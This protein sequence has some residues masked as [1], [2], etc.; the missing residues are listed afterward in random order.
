M[1]KVRVGLAI[2]LFSLLVSI[3]LEPV[4][5]GGAGQTEVR[6]SASLPWNIERIRAPQAW[7]ITQGSPEIVVAVIDSGIDFSIPEL[8]EVRWTNPKEILNRRDD[9]GNG[10]VDDL[11][12]W[13][14]RDNV[15]AHLRRTSLYYHGT[16]VAAVIAAQAQKLVGV[17]PEVRLMDVRFLDSRGY[18]Y[19]RDWK[20]LARAID[21]AVQNGARIINLSFYSKLPPPKEVEEA[22]KRAWEKGVIVVTIAGNEGREGV[23]PLGRCPFVLAVAAT[24]K[25]DRPASFSSF[26]PEV[27]LSAPGAEIPGFLPGGAVG[28]FSGTSF[29]APHVSGTLALILSANP[30]LSGKAA[31]E[32]LLSSA[33][34][35]PFGQTGFGQGLVNA[36]CAVAQARP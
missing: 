35:L 27:D 4:P 20:N 31:V 28:S 23:N 34:R 19:Q 9:D 36:G 7:S 10:Y 26:G 2:L 16:A 5:I 8:A 22:L 13:D 11:Y 15:P 24:D 17:A 14:F 30:R 33:D 6:L 1:E 3:A 21:Y 18:F 32:I 29:A 25:S 12:G